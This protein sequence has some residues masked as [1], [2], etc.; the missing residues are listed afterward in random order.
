MHNCAF[1]QS[2]FVIHSFNFSISFTHI[3]HFILNLSLCTTHT[4]RS[5]HS[6]KTFLS[7]ITITSLVHLLILTQLDSNLTYIHHQHPILFYIHPILVASVGILRGSWCY[8]D[9]FLSYS[10]SSPFRLLRRPG[11]GLYGT[12]VNATVILLPSGVAN[13]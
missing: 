9:M 8:R 1:L 12:A 2:V 6:N 7:S 11:F 5:K 10:L 3:I 4:Y 13:P